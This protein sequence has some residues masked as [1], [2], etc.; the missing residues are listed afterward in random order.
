[1]VLTGQIPLEALHI[2]PETRDGLTIVPQG[3]AGLS[4]TVTRLDLEGEIS[5]GF[6]N[7]ERRLAD[8]DGSIRAARDK[9]MIE[10]IGRDP[11]EPMLIAQGLGQ[12][13]GL[14][15]VIENLS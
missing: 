5:Q 1:V 13:F 14:A 3:P 4:Q 12:G 8:R 6:P 9:E 2:P 11:S 15:Q 10:H 7:S